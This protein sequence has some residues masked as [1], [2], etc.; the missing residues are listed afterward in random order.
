VNVPG[1]PTGAGGQAAPQRRTATKRKSSTKKKKKKATHRRRATR[2]RNARGHKKAG[3]RTSG[4]RKTRKRRPGQRVGLDLQ[5]RPVGGRQIWTLDAR[6]RARRPSRVFARRSS[7][8][9]V[10]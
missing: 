1:A 9:A 6:D 5:P 4:Q 10:E 7:P 3:K 8:T 2:H